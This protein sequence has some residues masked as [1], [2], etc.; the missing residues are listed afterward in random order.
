MARRGGLLP[1]ASRG[2]DLP[3][4]SR[5]CELC[6]I[7][8]LSFVF[9]VFFY[10]F[11]L[12]GIYSPLG[13]RFDNLHPRVTM[14]EGV[15]TDDTASVRV[16][17]DRG[18][19][20]HGGHIVRATLG[21]KNNADQPVFDYGVYARLDKEVLKI[22]DNSFAPYST[23]KALAYSVRCQLGSQASPDF[24]VSAGADI[25]AIWC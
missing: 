3:D 15:L 17:M 6:G 10:G 16:Y 5:S 2:S 11:F 14:S 9:T 23:C 25:N 20:T 4:Q 18:P 8:V 24:A 22:A 19:E 21:D 1:A 7:G 12:D 13:K